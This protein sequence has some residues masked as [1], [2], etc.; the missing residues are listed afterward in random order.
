MGHI[1]HQYAHAVSATNSTSLKGRGDTFGEPDNVGVGVFLE[2]VCVIKNE[3]RALWTLLHPIIDAI[4]NPA[5]GNRCI[6]RLA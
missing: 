6:S 2:A 3:R 5:A 1:L 4:K